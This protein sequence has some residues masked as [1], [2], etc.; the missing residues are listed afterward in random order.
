MLWCDY[1]IFLVLNQTNAIKRAFEHYLWWK[2]CQS[3]S[4]QLDF[5]CL[6]LAVC[7][8]FTLRKDWMLWLPAGVICSLQNQAAS[9]KTNKQKTQWTK[10]C[11]NSVD[12][13]HLEM[14]KLQMT[15]FEGKSS[16]LPGTTVFVSRNGF[17]GLSNGS[18]WLKH[19][20]LAPTP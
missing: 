11:L 20:L 10:Y 18:W 8:V 19:L 6:W 14:F 9:I 1:H 15:G 4:F 16:F 2:F 13:S 7:E 5:M 12:A 17:L 3:S